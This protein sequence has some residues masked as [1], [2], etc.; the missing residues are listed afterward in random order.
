MFEH[1]FAPINLIR[2]K[3]RENWT[4]TTIPKDTTET[5]LCSYTTDKVSTFTTS[6]Q[7][8]FQ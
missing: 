2:A 1:N 6:I 3:Q 4:G 8:K 7:K 5:S